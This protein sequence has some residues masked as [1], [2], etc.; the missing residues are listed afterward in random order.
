MNASVNLEEKT[1]K[2]NGKTF[3][4]SCVVRNELNGWRK[5]DQV[6]KSVPD[7]KPVYPRHFPVGSWR[8]TGV[9]YTDDPVFAPVKIKTN[10][11]QLLSVWELT[12]KGN[13][14]RRSNEVTKS[15]CYWLHHSAGS[16]TTLGCIR[17]NSPADALKIAAI[18]EKELE[19]VDSI[20][21]EVI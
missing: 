7:R 20:P 21:L 19:N 18:V 13:Y 8:I 12:K 2:I 14:K 3:F 9:E 5:K 4:I 16:S 10:A 6:I 15:T 17:L 11:Y 1:L